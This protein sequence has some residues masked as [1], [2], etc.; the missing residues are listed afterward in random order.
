MMASGCL[1]TYEP[2][3]LNQMHSLRHG[4]VPIVFRT[5]GLADM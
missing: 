4:T 5:G 3:G 1:S 2:C